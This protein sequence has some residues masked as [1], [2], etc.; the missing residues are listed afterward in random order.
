MKIVIKPLHE[1]FFA[2]ALMVVGGVIVVLIVAHGYADSL[3]AGEPEEKYSD[4]VIRI[5]ATRARI[6]QQLADHINLGDL[7]QL[8]QE[9]VMPA[10][11]ERPQEAVEEVADVAEE[12]AEQVSELKLTGI[13]W[14]FRNPVAFVNGEGV[15]VGSEI[16][17]WS[18]KEITA[19]SVMLADRDG[20]RR[21][22]M[23]YGGG[24]RE[25]SEAGSQKSEVGG[26]ESGVSM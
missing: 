10:V 11:E 7:G 26:R 5:R 17:G 9:K 25:K 20:N 14:S 1:M 21:Q 15:T 12:V 4:P 19:N 18:V 6:E 13:A 22:I 2:V 3:A 8:Y 16:G 23:M 24:G